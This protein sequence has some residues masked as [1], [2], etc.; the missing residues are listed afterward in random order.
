M[1]IN[2]R[3]HEEGDGHCETCVLGYPRL[4]DCGGLV[5]STMVND[6][7]GE[8]NPESA[9]DSCGDDFCEAD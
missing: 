2:D 5:H 4:C 3:E 9:C 7:M 1:M 8:K 6:D